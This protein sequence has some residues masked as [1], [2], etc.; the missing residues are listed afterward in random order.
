MPKLAIVGTVKLLRPSTLVVFRREN[1]LGRGA[2]RDYAEREFV[3]MET[4]CAASG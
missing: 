1:L 2:R 4:R 3:G